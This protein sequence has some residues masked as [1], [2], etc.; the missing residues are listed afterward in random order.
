MTNPAF[1]GDVPINREIVRWVGE[2]DICPRA[3][4]Q[5]LVGSRVEGIAAPNK[6]PACLPQVAGPSDWRFAS[7]THQFVSRIGPAFC[8]ARR[9]LDAKIDFSHRKTRDLE[10]EIEVDRRKLTQDLAE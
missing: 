1:A 4:H 6:V 2:D 10:A 7:G 8:P 9:L 3:S 5:C